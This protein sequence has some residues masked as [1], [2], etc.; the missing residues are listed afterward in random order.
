MLWVFQVV[1]QLIINS[2]FPESIDSSPFDA[3]RQRAH[4]PTPRIDI[5]MITLRNFSFKF[6]FCTEGTTHNAQSEHHFASSITTSSS[7]TQVTFVLFFS[8]FTSHHSTI[9][10]TAKVQSRSFRPHASCLTP[11]CV[12]SMAVSACV[13]L[14]SCQAFST[15][16]AIDNDSDL[17][18]CCYE[19]P[20]GWCEYRK[21]SQQWR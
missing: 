4:L 3:R 7:I 16:V 8:F 18:K 5:I 10:D 2:E 11:T 17:E 20:R 21:L 15:P 12:G 13:F 6:L 9:D 19:Q 14:G 1:D